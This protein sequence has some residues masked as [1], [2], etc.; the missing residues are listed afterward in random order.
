[1]KEQELNQEK[2]KLAG[3]IPKWEKKNLT[4]EEAAAY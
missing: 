3:K 1:M 2:K 4:I